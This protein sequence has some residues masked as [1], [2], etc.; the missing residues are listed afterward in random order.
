MPHSPPSPS[1]Q[2]ADENVSFTCCLTGPTAHRRC[3]RD[4]I[5]SASFVEIGCVRLREG[6]FGG[7]I[8]SRTAVASI[9]SSC[10]GRL[11]LR[12]AKF[13]ARRK[14][15]GGDVVACGGSAC[16]QESVEGQDP[17]AHATDEAVQRAPDCGFLT[18]VDAEEVSRNGVPTNEGDNCGN[19]RRMVRSVM[20]PLVAAS[21]TPRSGPSGPSCTCTRPRRTISRISRRIAR[22][23]ERV[24]GKATR[25]LRMAA[26]VAQ[27]S[28]TGIMSTWPGRA[29]LW[30][31]RGTIKLVAS[32]HADDQS[33]EFA[34]DES[35]SLQGS[36]DGRWAALEA[37]LGVRLAM[38]LSSP[39]LG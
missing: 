6:L 36:V 29:P 27:S 26:I 11:G 21:A 9:S 2:P 18:D 22:T 13:C 7:M 19:G 4:G 38:T 35:A 39:A 34:S 10:S 17:F 24:I 3:F 32:R 20:A 5:K 8:P 1:P 14:G 15:R 30:L 12:G 33:G 28:C 31:A 16:I 37:C 23:V 25:R